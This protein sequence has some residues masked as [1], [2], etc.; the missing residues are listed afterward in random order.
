MGC[1]RMR[2]WPGPGRNRRRRQCLPTRPGCGLHQPRSLPTSTGMP[3]EFLGSTTGPSYSQ[4]AC[5]AAQV[6]WRVRP[7]CEKL[8]IRSL[9]EWAESGNVF[10]ETKSHGVRKPVMRNRAAIFNTFR[11]IVVHCAWAIEVR[12]YSGTHSPC[13][14]RSRQAVRR[15]IRA[16]DGYPVAGSGALTGVA[17]P[18]P[19]GA[20]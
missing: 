11:R 6:T 2:K 4:S 18:A 13:R 16:A 20:D 5:S 3:V 10:K 14:S 7:Q 15:P 1:P 17:G 19:G 8:S 12:Q 9:H